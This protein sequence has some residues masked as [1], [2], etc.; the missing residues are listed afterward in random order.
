MLTVHTE[1]Y[2]NANLRNCK[3]LFNAILHLRGSAYV[4]IYM[5]TVL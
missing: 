5:C 3:N 1:L 2:I 4:Q